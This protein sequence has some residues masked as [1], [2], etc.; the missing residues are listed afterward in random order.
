MAFWAIGAFV[1]WGLVVLVIVAACNAE[2]HT[3]YSH[4]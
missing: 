1:I 3:D 2:D 4:D